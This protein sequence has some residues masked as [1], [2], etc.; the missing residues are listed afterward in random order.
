MVWT[1]PQNG[2]QSQAK[3]L[4]VD[5]AQQEE[6]RKTATIMGESSDGLHEKQTLVRM[7]E[8]MAEYR[9]L[10]LFEMDSLLL[11]LQILIK[12][13]LWLTAPKGGTPVNQ[14]SATDYRS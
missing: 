5:T 4:L 10:W 11:A 7:E 3:D 13:N 14:T 2:R 6:K 9:Q 8:N 12:I 1:P